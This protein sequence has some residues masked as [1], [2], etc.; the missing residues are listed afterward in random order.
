MVDVA[1]EYEVSIGRNA[2]NVGVLYNIPE[3]NVNQGII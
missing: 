3:Q 1:F 2:G